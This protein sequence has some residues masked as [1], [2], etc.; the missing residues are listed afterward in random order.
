MEIVCAAALETASDPFELAYYLEVVF[1]SLQG[2]TDGW[3]AL[4]VRWE[5]YFAH[6]AVT[7]R[8]SACGVLVVDPADPSTN[9]LADLSADEASELRREA[10]LAVTF[11]RD[12]QCSQLFGA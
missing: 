11:L 5:R 8:P 12:A 7:A 6:A 9:V 4:P 1:R 3:P 10:S 2:L